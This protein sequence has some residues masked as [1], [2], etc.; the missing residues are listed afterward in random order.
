MSDLSKISHNPPSYDCGIGL[1]VHVPFCQ[2]KCTYCD[3]NTYAGIEDQISGYVTTLRNEITGWGKVLSTP[4]VRTIFLGGGTPSFLPAEELDAIHSSIRSVFSINNNAEITMECNPGDITV[5]NAE[6]W[7]STGVNRISMGVQTFNDQLLALLGRRHTALEAKQA[8]YKVRAAGFTNQ[9]IDL[10]YGLPYQT[11]QQWS[12]TVKEAITLD[13]EHI[14]IYSLQIEQGTPLAVDV[15]SGKY[16]MPDDDLAADMYEEAQQ[17]LNVSGY[18]QYE[19]SNWAKPGMES[20]HNLI[21]WRNEPY[22][23]V[24]PGAHSWVDARRFSNLKSPKRYTVAVQKSYEYQP[25]NPVEH[26]TFPL[27]PVEKIEITTPEI[28]V[29]ETMM[30]GMRLNDGI[31]H[32]RFRNRFGSE[33]CEIFPEEINHLLDI[34]LIEITDQSVK[35]SDKGRL[36][37]N[38]VFAEF[39]TEPD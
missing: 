5:E 6:K 15:E 13:P 25:V 20:K 14:S 2:T 35:L 16:P 8:F 17:S 28:D 27:G 10:I 4:P 29:A 19:I 1:Y 38:E 9:S 39:I 22:L 3:F 23:G 30:M 31:S 18:V 37:G 11:F 12:D 7:L 32:R 26:M 34:G 36:L 33:I 24:G 21:Y